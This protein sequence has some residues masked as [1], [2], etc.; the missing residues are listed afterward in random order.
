MLSREA[1]ESS[2][3]LCVFFLVFTHCFWPLALFVVLCIF[4]LV[5]SQKYNLATGYNCCDTS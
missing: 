5:L 3:G 1:L 4:A 2:D